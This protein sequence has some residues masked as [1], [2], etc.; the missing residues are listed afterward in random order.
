MNRLPIRVLILFWEAF[1]K[2]TPNYILFLVKGFP[3]KWLDLYTIYTPIKWGVHSHRG[4][5]EK[6]VQGAPPRDFEG[7][8]FFRPFL[9]G[10]R[11]GDGGEDGGGW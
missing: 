11:V 1:Q 5:L 2:K 3:L 9:G 4:F 8:G 6:I 7:V 10:E